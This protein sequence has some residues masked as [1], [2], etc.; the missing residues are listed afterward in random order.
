MKKSITIDY[1]KPLF[2]ELPSLDEK[3]DPVDKSEY[4]PF[5]IQQLQL[6]N[7]IYNMFFEMNDNNYN[8]IA[9]NHPF[10]IKDTKHIMDMNTNDPFEFCI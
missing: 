1:T 5:S 8:R 7:P 2:I 3:L 10:H 4:N 9:L 6:Y